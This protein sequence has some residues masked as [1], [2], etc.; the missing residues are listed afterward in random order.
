MHDYETYNFLG[1]GEKMSSYVYNSSI[2][3]DYSPT[4]SYV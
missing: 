3:L 1:I 4:I 2:F